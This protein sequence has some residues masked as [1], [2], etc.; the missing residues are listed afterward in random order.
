MSCCCGCRHLNKDYVCSVCDYVENKAGNM[1]LQTI[2]SA[3]LTVPPHP[4][5]SMYGNKSGLIFFKN[6]W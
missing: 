6:N 1:S 3:F 5:K 4:I 2:A